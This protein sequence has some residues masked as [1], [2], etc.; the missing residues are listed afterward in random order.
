[1]NTEIRFGG[2]AAQMSD[3]DCQDGELDLSLNAINED[4]AV[5][6]AFCA[7]ENIGNIGKGNRLLV[8]H[9]LSTGRK[10]F[11]VYSKTKHCIYAMEVG[12]TLPEDPFM[13]LGS[14]IELYDAKC[15]GNTLILM[16][17]EGLSYALWKDGSYLSLGNMPVVDMNVMINSAAQTSAELFDI[18]LPEA[19][20]DKLH[21]SSNNISPLSD[22]VMAAVNKA[23]KENSFSQPFL[24]RYALRLYDGTLTHHSSPILIRPGF[25]EYPFVTTLGSP[26]GK[27]SFQGKVYIPSISVGVRFAD[28]NVRKALNDWQDIIVA[29]EFFASAPLYTYEQSGKVASI[30]EISPVRPKAMTAFGQDFASSENEEWRLPLQFRTAHEMT[31]QIKDCCNFYLCYTI[32]PEET[33]TLDSATGELVD[34]MEFPTGASIMHTNILKTD[35]TLPDDL[36]SRERI[37]P[38]VGFVYNDRLNIAD[39][40]KRHYHQAP[41]LSYIC[42]A[43]T[44]KDDEYESGLTDKREF[45]ISIK[46]YTRRDGESLSYQTAR[47]TTF[48]PKNICSYLY[49]PDKN[50]YKAVIW[51]YRVGGG[52]MFW[53]E[54]GMKPHDFLN[55]SYYCADNILAMEDS[56]FIADSAKPLPSDFNYSALSGHGI[57]V[58]DEA[59][60]KIYV[61]D[62]AN[63]FTFPHTNTVVIPGGA[64]VLGVSAAA[65]ALSQGQ[66]GQFPLYAFTTDGVWALEVS[67]TG[68]YSARQPIT[69]DVCINPYA[70]TQIDSS[71][72]FPTSRGVMLIAG[73]ECQSVSDAINA[74]SIFNHYGLPFFDKLHPR[75]SDSCLPVTPLRSFLEKARIAYDYPNQRLIFFNPI[76]EGSNLAYVFSVKSRCWGMM[77]CNFIDITNSYPDA[78]VID[79]NYNILNLS[80]GYSVDEMLLSTR[81]FKITGGDNYK[82]VNTVI[83]RGDFNRGDVQLALYSSNDLTNWHLVSSSVDHILRGIHGSAYKFF[84]LVLRCRLSLGQSVSGISI[85]FT[86]KFTNSLR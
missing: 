69:R 17:S 9:T 19:I 48:L 38:K 13:T 4:G 6:P 42:G 15:V 18:S 8:I 22:A 28:E 33:K 30:E 36:L 34:V 44:M 58:H 66:F 53:K 25:G 5:R 24:L 61:S 29:I 23:V 7:G 2:L 74:R 27:S 77:R 79:N 80:D 63:P 21:V 20:S 55:G 47:S 41:A 81:P 16:T 51:I 35:E 37:I 83:A 85:R 67:S 59:G 14:G 54:V 65:R 56:S 76:E 62:A 71:V 32:K 12:G 45:Y 78:Y 57:K 86:P 10:H 11:I 72:L 49:H 39:C 75:N 46:F 26:A 40:M 60:G 52:G 43:L 84:R 82:T 3:Y 68:S 70:I 73:S 64:K 31:K 1:M 50:V